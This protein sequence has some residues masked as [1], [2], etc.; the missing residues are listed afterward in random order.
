MANP[1]INPY[2]GPRTF[3]YQ[4][5]D[6]FFGREWEARELL[7]RVI[8]ERVTLF[9]AQSG[10]GKSSLLN[11]R[12]IPQL[13]AENFIVLP[14][15]RVSGELPAGIGRVGNIFIFNLLLS[16][17]QSHSNPTRFAQIS[18]SDFATNLT[19]LDGQYFYYDETL[20]AQN[21]AAHVETQTPHVLIID[22]FEEIVT[23]HLAR[24][25]EREGFFR[26]LTQLLAGDPLLW[27]VL[28]VREDYTAMLEPYAHLLPNKMQNRFYMQRMNYEAALEAVQ[29]PA[30]QAGRPFAPGVAEMLV[31]NLRQIRVQGQ[32]QTQ[33]GQF[34]EPVQLQVVCYQLW[35]NLKEQSV[36]EITAQDLQE[37]GNIDTTL[38]EFYEQ[39]LADAIIA[40]NISE[41]E[42]RHWFDEKLITEA[43]TRGTVY[44]GQV[45]TGGLPNTVVDFLARRFLLRTETRIGGAWYELVHDRFVEPIRQAN[46]RWRER[47]PLIQVAQSWINSGRPDSLLLEG[48]PLKEALA[49][50]W[51]GL[52]RLVEVFLTASQTTQQLK[53]EALRAEKE[54]QRQRELE[55]A[56][57]LA[58]EAE[59]R[60]RAEA[61]RAEEAEKRAREQVEATA[62]LRQRLFW[63][64]GAGLFALIMTL[65]AIIF[66]VRSSQNEA[67]AEAAQV[68]AQFEA[69]RA[70]NAEG[71]AQVE[72]TKAI[73]AGATALAAKGTA[74]ADAA[75]A[76]EARAI[77][78][79]NLQT[80]VAIAAIAPSP[81]LIP[82]PTPTPTPFSTPSPQT[83]P[84]NT[85]TPSPTPTINLAATA[86]ARAVQTLQVQLNQVIATQTVA[87]QTALIPSPTPLLPPQGRI[88]F[89]SHRDQQPDARYLYLVKVEGSNVTRLTSNFG[90]EPNYSPAARRIIFSRPWLDG[91]AARVSLYT[92]NPDGQEEINI[93][94]RLWDNWEPAWSP[95][96]K[97]IAFNSSRE[98]RDWEIYTM[99]SDGSNITLLNCENIDKD[100]LKWAPAWSPDGQRLAFVVSPQ[101]DQYQGQADIW[102]MDADGTDCKPLTDNIT[103][104]RHVIAK[105]PDW[106]PLDGRSIIFVS[107]QDG[108]FELY[109]IDSNGSNL[110]KIP[111]SPLHVNYPA[112]SPDGNWLTFSVSTRRQDHK[113]DAIF[114]MTVTGEGQRNLS[115]G[116]GEDWYSV[117]LPD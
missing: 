66:G 17:D 19:T 84:T 88:I 95:D 111:N 82:S 112:W 12:L 4:E 30:A 104:Q 34:V 50:D 39:A 65:V 105:Y 8:S 114:I 32:S 113:P 42:L 3:T 29:K 68:T 60:R 14:V 59:A 92:A 37:L 76:N 55:V 23:T 15:G 45:F 86:T 91:A 79:A 93:D 56:H 103:S 98:N 7:A 46:R 9:Y 109:R 94:N 117:W 36:G 74:E 16:L 33:P 77:L 38:A 27:V 54:A 67:Q 115:D 64:V 49:T 31:D 72:A 57:Q 69:V 5:S 87:A 110:R 61:E 40:T 53:D 108:N 25:Q 73:E 106:S 78:I 28:V 1:T 20:A 116:N 41:I 85:P 51:R 24:W 107:N 102:I 80:Q 35:E 2:V 83:G 81:T 71:T 96:G 47:Q 22:Q 89:V 75:A 26:Q 70:L 11:T 43:G 10:A 48:Q 44:R 52:G 58:E 63:S 97:Q 21:Q 6:R 101:R 99:N 90:T 100:L 13:Q 62:K 18:L